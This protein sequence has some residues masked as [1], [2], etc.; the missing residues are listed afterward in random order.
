MLKMFLSRFCRFFRL[1]VKRKSWGHHNWKQT[2]CCTTQKLHLLIKILLMEEI[3]H[4]KTLQIMGAQTQ[5]GPQNNGAPNSPSKTTRETTESPAT[6]QLMKVKTCSKFEFLITK[7]I[8]MFFL[9]PLRNRG[10]F[11]TNFSKESKFPKIKHI[12]Q[13]KVNGESWFIGVK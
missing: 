1:S 12:S 8:L 4:Y 7:L 6:R 2:R 9:L 5:K 3:L 10:S 11:P 13:P